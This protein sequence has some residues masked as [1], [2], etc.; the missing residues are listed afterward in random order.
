MVGGGRDVESYGESDASRSPTNGGT[1][2]SMCMCVFKYTVHRP[3]PR[4]SWTLP[5]RDQ[6]RNA[7]GLEF[8]THPRYPDPEPSHPQTAKYIYSDELITK[9]RK[10]QASRPSGPS[11]AFTITYA[12][13]N[14][15][16]MMNRHT[17]KAIALFQRIDGIDVLLFLM[18]VQEYPSDSLGSNARRAYIGYLDSVGE[19]ACM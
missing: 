11:Q 14:N 6:F 4:H 18:Y 16:P 10:K 8:H 1:L 3:R 2:R 7:D 19:S 15:V 5:L 12:T 9:S 17:T 13:S